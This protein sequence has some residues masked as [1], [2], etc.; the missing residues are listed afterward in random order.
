M[1]QNNDFDGFPGLKRQMVK[2]QGSVLCKR[3]F[4][5]MRLE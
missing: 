4:D 5:A 2:R 1:G 3:C